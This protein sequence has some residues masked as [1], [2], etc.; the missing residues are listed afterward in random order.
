MD[1]LKYFYEEP[2]ALEALSGDLDPDARR[3]EGAAALEAFLAAPRRFA[4]GYLAGT[5]RA[6]GRV[7]LTALAHPEAFVAPLMALGAGTCWTHADRAGTIRQPTDAA[8][9]AILQNPAETAVLACADEPLD[10]EAVRAVGGA[11]RRYALPA[12]RALLDAAQVVFFP[13]PAHHG[14]D[15]SL[16]AAEPVRVRLVEAFR[17]H[18]VEGVR[19]FVL[20]FQRARSEHQ[21]YFEAWR[22]DEPLPDY[23]E[24][25]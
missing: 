20:P 4:R 18:P 11:A 12:L 5:D 3:R 16:Y 6:S 7:G 23:V 19:R 14:F 17:Q 25:L 21:F 22:L 10:A 13:E 9:R 15:W 8:V 1:I 2:V 24:E